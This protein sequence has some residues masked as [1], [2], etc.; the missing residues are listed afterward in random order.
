M[1]SVRYIGMDVHRE[2][3][4]VAVL[5]EG[6]RVMMQSVL[7]TRAAAMHTPK[8]RAALLSLLDRETRRGALASFASRDMLPI[9]PVLEEAAKSDQGHNGRLFV[10][11][12]AS[13]TIAA[14]MNRA[15]SR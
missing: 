4:S 7:A 11:E 8:V 10:R 13:D 14:I 15:N 6:G 5:D 12:A 9:I 3:I 2:T 1:N